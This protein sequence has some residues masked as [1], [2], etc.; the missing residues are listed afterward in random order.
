MVYCNET[1]FEWLLN[2]AFSHIRVDNH[3]FDD[4]KGNLRQL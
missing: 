4:F 3:S 1:N 2:N